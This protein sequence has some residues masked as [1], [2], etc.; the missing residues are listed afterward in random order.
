MTASH[1]YVPYLLLSEIE[2]DLRAAVRDLV[3]RRV[4]PARLIAGYDD[5]SALPDFWAESA[6]MGLTGLLIPEECGGSGAGIAVAAVVAE[7]LGVAAAPGPFLTCAGI[8]ATVLTA[9][10]ATS[11]LERVA[12]GDD[13]VALAVPFSTDPYGPVPVVETV[14]GRLTGQVR[15]VAGAVGADRLLVPGSGGAL[16]VVDAADAEVVPVASL[17]MTRQVADIRLDGSPAERLADDATRAIRIGLT[18]GACLLAAEQAG[19]ARWCVTESVTYLKERRQFGRVV[20]GFQAIKHR[21]AELYADSESAA[22]I[23]RAAAV[24]AADLGAGD[25]QTRI[26]IA[27]AAA[28]CSDLAVRAAEEAVQLHGGIG[29]TWEHPIHVYLKRAKADQI[30]LGGSGVHRAALAELIDLPSAN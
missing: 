14:D 8:A 30:A 29:M 6:Q 12:G 11:G 1:T 22:A 15:S 5:P 3:S 24:T 2:C 9:A 27:T 28:Y 18:V 16:Y 17:D 26:A 10:G 20:G 25:R 7:E 4:P 21:L 13:V 23:A 19:V